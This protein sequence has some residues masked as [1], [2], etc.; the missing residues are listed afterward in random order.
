MRHELERILR[1][2]VDLICTRLQEDSARGVI[3]IS[4]RLTTGDLASSL[5]HAQERMPQVVWVECAADTK[6]SAT[7]GSASS[8][9]ACEHVG[10]VSYKQRVCVTIALA[11]LTPWG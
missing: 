7:L 1:L 9:L 10:R 2:S 5:A 4:D 6:L 8:D 11:S 3:T